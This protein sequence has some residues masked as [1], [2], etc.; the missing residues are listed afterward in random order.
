MTQ[1]FEILLNFMAKVPS[2][3]VNFVCDFQFSL[4]A[5]LLQLRDRKT[6]GKG[7]ELVPPKLGPD[8][9]FKKGM[10]KIPCKVTIETRNH[11]PT[12]LENDTV[13]GLNPGELLTLIV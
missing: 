9:A 8:S 3:K 5:V 6:S 12:W 7:K 1:N 13:N 10:P 2:K 11:Q 4:A